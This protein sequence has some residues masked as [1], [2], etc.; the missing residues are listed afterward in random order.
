MTT[1][2]AFADQIAQA[3]ECPPGHVLHAWE[4]AASLARAIKNGETL[5]AE[6]K[7]EGV[8]GRINFMSEGKTHLVSVWAPLTFVADG[9]QWA[10]LSG[11]SGREM[12]EA[13]GLRDEI[14]K[15]LQRGVWFTL[16]LFDEAPEKVFPVD[17]AGVQRLVHDQYPKI[18]AKIGNHWEALKTK[19]WAELGGESFAAGF[20]G[21]PK[22]KMN[23]ERYAE[24]EDTAS[25]AR[26]FLYNTVNLSSLFK[27]DGYS[28]DL[29][30]GHAVRQGKEY[31][32]PN[33][34]LADIP[35]DQ[36]VPLDVK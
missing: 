16:A 32:V 29:V 17:W 7:F 1:Q 5:S 4:D 10:R 19:S 33:R 34:P 12:L 8:Y 26:W 24:A 25:N 9:A 27:G 15:A 36:H 22:E 20:G 3:F 35:E 23:E 18:E 21:D 31:L 13:V 14:D 30:G 6:K 28:Y 11:K 2:R